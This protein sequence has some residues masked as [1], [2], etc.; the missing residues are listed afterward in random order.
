[1]PV[2]VTEQGALVI[3]Q[4]KNVLHEISV[5]KELAKSHRSGL[6]GSLRLGIIPT[7]APY[8]LPL[9]LKAFTDSHPELDVQV[10]EMNTDNILRN[11][12][13]DHLDVGILATPLQREGFREEPLFYE[14][15]R[16]YSGDPAYQPKKGLLLAEDIDL[17]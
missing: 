4:A 8:L 14:Q 5:L 16:V 12:S 3:R 10:M 6:K 9:F 17:E 11:L 13:Q 1:Q 7:L 15:F 2:Q